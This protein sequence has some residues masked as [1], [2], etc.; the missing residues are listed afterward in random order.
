MGWYRPCAEA[1]RVQ[2]NTPTGCDAVNDAGYSLVKF[3][4]AKG[5]IVDDLPYMRLSEMYLIW[6]EAAARD[7]NSPALGVD[8]LQTL[9]D[10]RN[11]GTVPAT[12]LTNMTAFEDFILDERMRELALEGHRFFDLKRMGRDIRNPDGSIK[13]RADSYRILPQIGISLRNVNP[14]LVENPGY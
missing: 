14:Q 12:A 11:A 2:L 9:L 5:Q 1:Q 7:G 13:M 8:P 4:G 3:N 10:A 6:S